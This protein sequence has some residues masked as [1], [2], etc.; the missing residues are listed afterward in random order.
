MTIKNLDKFIV[1]NKVKFKDKQH[2]QW[3]MLFK[4]SNQ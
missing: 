1:N 4:I 2:V 3:N